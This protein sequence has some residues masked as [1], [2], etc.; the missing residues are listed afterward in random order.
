MK[1]CRDSM[2]KEIIEMERKK[3]AAKGR[4]LRL[5]RPLKPLYPKAAER[6]YYKGLRQMVVKARDLVDEI[7][8]PA[9]PSIL[10]SAQL[11]RPDRADSYVDDVDNLMEITRIGFL[12][13]YS[14]DELDFLAQTAARR[15]AITNAVMIDK[16]L[17]AV[18][19]VQPLRS[20]PWLAAHMEAFVNTNVKLI[21]TIPEKYFADV[22]G[23]VMRGATRGEL[24]KTM[25]TE[26]ADRFGV[27]ERR[28]KLIARDQVG[29]FNGELSRFRQ[30]EVGIEKYTWS[31]SRDSRVRPT[32]Q[33]LDGRV[34]SWDKPPIEGHP[35]M[36]IQCRCVAIPVIE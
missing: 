1:V 14:P 23:I 28:A 22:E 16:T 30:T 7:I 18:L 36:A 13:D 11:L 9:I 34:F 31:T 26:I 33:D 3:A 19:H 8:V 29:S 35:G 12:R 21:K 6:E 24:A 4:K 17:K 5:R 20:E 32:H 2:I 25:K 15:V 27:T 10:A